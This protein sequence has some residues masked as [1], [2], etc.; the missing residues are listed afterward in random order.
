[1]LLT[2]SDNE[3]IKAAVV[4]GNRPELNVITGP[5]DL[6]SFATYWISLCWHQLPQQ[7]P[8]FYGR[9]ATA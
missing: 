3:Q 1:M 2:A 8:S 5:D 9:Y 6:M 4:H 7:R